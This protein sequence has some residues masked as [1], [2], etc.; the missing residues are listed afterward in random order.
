MKRI[1]SLLL[2]VLLCQHTNA[3]SAFLLKSAA[4]FYVGF[5]ENWKTMPG[6]VIVNKRGVK[7]TSLS[8]AYL[9]GQPGKAPTGKQWISKYGSVGFSLLGADMLCYGMNE[10][11]LYLVELYLDKTYSIADQHKPNMFWAQWIQYQL[12]NYKDVDEMLK[13][14]NEAP[15]IDWWP[16][17]PGSHFFVADKSG[18]TAA[19]ELLN[20]KMTVSTGK[21]MPIKLLCNNEYQKDLQSLNNYLPFGGGKLFDMSANNWNDRFI[22]A[23]HLLYNYNEQTSGNP[24]NYS[25]NILDSV[26]P[27]EWQMVADMNNTKLY[28]RS[29]ISSNIKEIDLSKLDFSKKASLK[30]VDINT[31]K[32]G[33]VINQLQPFSA[34]ANKPYTEKGFVIAYDNKEF[35]GSAA[36]TNVIENLHQ[37]IKKL[38]D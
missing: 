16:T 30:Y 8:W 18:N 1:V 33:D 10:K 26:N 31:N 36:F 23:A 29:D 2:L 15:V 37:Y 25:W 38:Y 4:N 22:K 14:L 7:K 32:G 6:M 21:N 12:D 11:G 34:A 19:I 35:P 17:F 3:C 27:G 9:A 28:F 24:L 13:H 5:N 20:G